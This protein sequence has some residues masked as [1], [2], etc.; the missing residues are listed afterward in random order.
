MAEHKIGPAPVAYVTVRYPVLVLADDTD[1][2][3]DAL[4]DLISRVVEPQKAFPG[5]PFE[6]VRYINDRRPILHYT[7]PGEIVSIEDHREDERVVAARR[8]RAMVPH[9]TKHFATFLRSL[10]AWLEHS[11][12]ITDKAAEARALASARALLG[13][14]GEPDGNHA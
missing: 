10:A 13:Q 3:W 7:D 11:R 5:G 1:S 12:N 4:D 9:H 2:D 14:E 6:G 8:L